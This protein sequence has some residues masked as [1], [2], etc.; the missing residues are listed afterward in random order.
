MI[1]WVKQNGPRLISRMPVNITLAVCF[2]VIVISSVWP[3]A[4]SVPTAARMGEAF[5]SPLFE[6]QAPALRTILERTPFFLIGALVA[7]IGGGS[8]RSLQRSGALVL[9]FAVS[10]ELIQLFLVDRHARWNDLFLALGFS[11]LGLVLGAT[12]RK[13]AAPRLVFVTKMASVAGLLSV[14]A[15]LLVQAHTAKSL[16]SWECGFGLHLG[17]EVS[18]DRA[19]QG[20]II[21]FSVTSPG[22]EIS[23][24][25]SSGIASPL[26]IQRGDLRTFA[27]DNASFCEAVKAA[28]FFEATAQIRFS[29]EQM[30][31]PARIL[32]WSKN[33]YQQNFLL[34]E[35]EQSV[36]FRVM[37]GAATGQVTTSLSA[38]LPQ[39]HVGAL[40][41]AVTYDHGRMS[42]R[43]DG[44]EAARTN[45][46][47]VRVGNGLIVSR[48]LCVTLLLGLALLICGQMLIHTDE[49]SPKF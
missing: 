34:G 27:G 1:S 11:A 17:N 3:F 44:I 16:K 33:I 4:F 35:A 19:W 40:T 18:K 15:L 45:V 41:I 12:Y 26:A 7:G 47:G 5:S 13:I 14:A 9:G 28:Q 30:Q 29:G 2:C 25:P 49:Q 39:N 31:G 10:I 24:V 8:T 43:F 23:I 6:L 38:P 21:S 46:F 36:V 20:E 37:S 42:I 48:V 32:S 22:N